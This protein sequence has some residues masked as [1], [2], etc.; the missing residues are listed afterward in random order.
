MQ[1]FDVPTDEIDLSATEFWSAPRD[2]RESAFAKLRNEAPILFFEEMDFT[3]VPKGPGYF[4]LTR[5][6]DIWLVRLGFV[7]LQLL[8]L[9][10]WLLPGFLADCLV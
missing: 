7:L 5:H 6:E 10:S 2:Y 1:L 8:L 4:A 9:R 3:F